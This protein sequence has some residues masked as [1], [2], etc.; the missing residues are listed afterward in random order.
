[1]SL[2]SLAPVSLVTRSVR[3]T[4]WSAGRSNT[5]TRFARDAVA[6]LITEME[7]SDLSVRRGGKRAYNYNILRGHVGLDETK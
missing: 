1:V 7:A 6:H 3:P 2:R 4:T 5:S